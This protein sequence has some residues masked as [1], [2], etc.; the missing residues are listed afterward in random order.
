MDDR[1]VRLCMVGAGNHS[2]RNIVPIFYFLKEEA[3]VVANCDLEVEKARVLGERFGIRR[4]Y[5]D[6]E[7]MIEEEQPDGVIVCISDTAHAELAPRIMRMGRHVYVEKPHAPS[8][9]KS[10][11]MLE[12]SRETGRICMVA[13]KK[14]FAPA[15]RKA[16]QAIDSE[17]FG[18]PTMIRMYRGKGGSPSDDPA[19]LWRWGCHV[20]D[21][22]HYLF[23]QVEQVQAFKS[24]QDW[25]SV[26]LNLQFVNGAAGTLIYCSPGPNWE[27]VTAV[28]EGMAGLHVSNSIFLTRYHGNAPA[29]GHQPSFVAG[30][31]HSSVEMGFVGELQEF[32]A[33]IREGRQP[34][35][36]IAQATH[37]R[38]LHEAM[39]NSLESGQ[40]QPVEQFDPAELGA[41][42]GMQ[43]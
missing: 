6:Y 31:T 3:E 5:A 13:F 21:L 11:R 12:V 40:P 9:E 16:R 17:E 37:T 7:R 38:A 33:A 39:M 22:I 14:R 19:Y 28:G 15:Y 18:R 43:Q 25:S 26:T 10:K 42:A 23:G 2:S 30:N 1:R 24:R 4:H 27:E 36:N 34:E 41:P 32:V 8:L 35:S 29:G 20:T